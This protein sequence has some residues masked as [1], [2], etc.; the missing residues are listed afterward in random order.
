M[1]LAEYLAASTFVHEKIQGV[2]IIDVDI[3]AMPRL[4]EVILC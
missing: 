4:V 1:I 2:N 3:P